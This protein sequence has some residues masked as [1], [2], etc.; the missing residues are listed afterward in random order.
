MRTL[1]SLK[2]VTAMVLASAMMVWAQ[3]A[4]QTEIKH[5]PIQQTSPASGTEM[6]KTYCAVCHGADGRGNG[7]AAEALKVAPTDLTMLATKNGGKYPSLK[8]SAILRGENPLA[9]HGTKEM[10]IWGNLFWNLSNG[11]QSEVEQRISNLNRYLESIQ[12]K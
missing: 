10:P 12:K 9:A 1:K 8:V 4:A 11:H 6:Y 7:P 5:V 2:I 3:G